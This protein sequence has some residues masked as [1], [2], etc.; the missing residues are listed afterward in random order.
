VEKKQE[1]REVTG[2]KSKCNSD[3]NNSSGKGEQTTD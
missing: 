1:N 2:K 3:S